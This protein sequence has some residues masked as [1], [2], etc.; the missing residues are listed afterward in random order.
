[1]LDPREFYEVLVEQSNQGFF[2]KNCYTTMINHYEK[3]FEISDTLSKCLYQ[4]T[5]NNMQEWE[6]IDELTYEN[7]EI[8]WWL[9]QDF[10]KRL[11]LGNDVNISAFKTVDNNKK[12]GYIL[13]RVSEEIGHNEELWIY[14]IYLIEYPITTNSIILMPRRGR[15]TLLFSSIRSML[16]KQASDKRAELQLESTNKSAIETD[17]KEQKKLVQDSFKPEHYDTK[18]E[19]AIKEYKRYKELDNEY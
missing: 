10:K 15:G 17:K 4:L 6:S 9:H 12:D 2:P 3:I 11:Q 1:M 19:E 7:K 18:L 13:I 8:Y 16:L 5:K 14:K